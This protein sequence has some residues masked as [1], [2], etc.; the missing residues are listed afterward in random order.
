MYITHS[1]LS[2]DIITAFPKQ[3]TELSQSTTNKSTK[4]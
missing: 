3:Q 4:Q 1:I 2:H